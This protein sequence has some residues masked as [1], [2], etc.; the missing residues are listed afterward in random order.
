MNSLSP[1]LIDDIIGHVYEA[2]YDI[3]RNDVGPLEKGDYSDLLTCSLV[4]RL[5]LLSSQRRLFHYIILGSVSRVEAKIQRLDQVLLNSPHLASSIQVLY[6][7]DLDSYGEYGYFEHRHP[8]CI[9]IDK[10]LSSLL[11]KCTH[12]QQSLCRVLELPSMVFVYVHRTRFRYTDHFTNF[13]NH[14][15]G[16]TGLTSGFIETSCPQCFKVE[17][18]QAE[19]NKEKFERHCI[20]H[21]TRLNVVCYDNSLS[22]HWLLGPRSHVDLLHVHTLHIFICFDQYVSVNRLLW[23]VGSSLKHITIILPSK[24]PVFVNL[25]FNVNIEILSLAG[26]NMQSDT[27]STLNH[28]LS[29]IDASNHIHHIGLTVDPGCGANWQVDWPAWEEVYSVLAGPLFQFLR[30]L[31][32]NVGPGNRLLHPEPVVEMSRDMVAA[33]PVLATRGVRVSFCEQT[34]CQC[35]SC[36]NLWS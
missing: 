7:P 32:I 10:R 25:A 36:Y 13:T 21:L 3:C 12:L 17:A 2:D 15:R 27:L 14:A 4:C 8:A 34:S 5:W 24:S 30:V 19:D 33:Y 20:S 35:V 28:V 29:T 22:A 9:A 6:L 23:A 18:K 16:L 31:C 1:E 26:M 11:H